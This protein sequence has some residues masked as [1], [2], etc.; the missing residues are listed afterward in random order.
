MELPFNSHSQLATPEKPIAE[1]PPNNS[2]EALGT[3]QDA[4][5]PA[6]APPSGVR[7]GTR[8]KPNQES[9]ESVNLFTLARKNRTNKFRVKGLKPVVPAQAR[10]KRSGRD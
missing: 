10:G 3:Q 4:H 7:P 5:S 1:W 6:P 8:D 9:M 2:P